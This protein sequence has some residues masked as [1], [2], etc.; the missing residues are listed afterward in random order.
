[1]KSS[2][3]DNIFKKK[4]G[5]RWP[6]FLI[7]LILCGS[8][9]FLIFPTISTKERIEK[10]QKIA[11]QNCK[12]IFR[13]LDKWKKNDYDAN[14]KND[15]ILGPLKLLSKIKFVSGKTISLLNEKVSNAEFRNENR[16]AIDGYFY[17]LSAINKQW[18]ETGIPTDEIYIIA[19]P[20]KRGKTGTCIFLLNS[21]NEAL[22][23]SAEYSKKIPTWPNHIE[24]KLKIWKKIIL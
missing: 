13:A 12:K 14:G 15:Y 3:K 21:K 19:I 7:V 5:S 24:E 6:F 4:K 11:I 8:A 2:Y 1:M 16:K 23:C 22:Y 18:L 17:T 9:F 10:N 20:E